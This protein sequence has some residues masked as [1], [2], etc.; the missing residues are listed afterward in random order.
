MLSILIDLLEIFS[1]VFHCY[2]GKSNRARHLTSNKTQFAIAI[3]DG[4]KIVKCGQQQIWIVGQW[5][6]YCV[7]KMRWSKW[8]IR[9][10]KYVLSTARIWSRRVKYL[11]L[12]RWMKKNIWY[13]KHYVLWSTKTLYKNLMNIILATC[14]HMHSERPLNK[15]EYIEIGDGIRQ[16]P[17][18]ESE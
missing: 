1:C 4:I 6:I 10:L 7:D 3:M 16:K 8:K 2:S 18:R 11:E 9:H 13:N 12:C 5:I 15:M 14:F 17:R